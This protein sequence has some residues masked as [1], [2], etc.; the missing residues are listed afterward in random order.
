MSRIF[1]NFKHP[2]ARSKQRSDAPNGSLSARHRRFLI[3][4]ISSFI[5]C[6]LLDYEL[7]SRQWFL[8]HFG[9][10]TLEG[11][12]VRKLQQSGRLAEVADV[13]AF[14]SS[15]TRSG[16]S[17]E[18][19]LEKGLLPFNFA[20]SGGGPVYA[21][22][23]LEQIAPVLAQRSTKP[24]L[25]MELSL[26]TLG[27]N[28]AEEQPGGGWSEYQ[29]LFAV[30]R[31]RRLIARH[32]LLL[33]ENFREYSE[34]SE[35]LSA[36]F[37]PSSSYRAYGRILGAYTPS[38]FIDA[39][40]R[41][42]RDGY[43]YGFEDLGGFAPLYATAHGTYQAD[44][45]PLPLERFV[46]AK[47]AFLKLFIERALQLGTRVVL[48]PIPS[49][50][51]GYYLALERLAERLKLEYPQIRIIRNRDYGLTLQDFDV[52]GHLNIWGADHFAQWLIA[53]LHLVGDQLRLDRNI[54]AAFEKVILPPVGSWDF[55]GTEATLKR[56]SPY[57]LLWTPRAANQ[58]IATSPWISVTA[59]RQYV[60][61]FWALSRSGNFVVQIGGIGASPGAV[62]E[63]VT[64]P[65]V[66]EHPGEIRYFL[67]VTPND[68]RIRI[69]ISYK[70]SGSEP[71]GG[72]FIRLDKFYGH[73]ER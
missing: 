55:S 53:N 52:S 26:N 56:S 72:G 25:L 22:Y 16:L 54:R 44:F 35:F 43:F 34:S 19:F 68:P 28:W 65:V 30:A 51:P 71:G 66:L 6:Y 60:L 67:P 14:G 58:T 41:Q 23:A 32:F 2:L 15:Y 63:T 45:V 57:Q 37:W 5:I 49:S 29:Q 10:E 33:R 73:I 4:L 24:L 1:A 20:V 12:V 7:Y 17:T 47:V 48:Y 62:T 11:Q 46:P 38:Q 61:E 50:Q 9:Y 18:P 64:V 69:R 31:S 36:A 70:R 40:A 39:L 13:I 8:Q 21:Y 27:R 3:A 59:N 42:R